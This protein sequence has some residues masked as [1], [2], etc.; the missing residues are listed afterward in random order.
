[1]APAA[2]SGRCASAK[3]TLPTNRRAICVMS[4]AD[5]RPANP[6]P[7][8]R[9]ASVRALTER[10]MAMLERLAE[11]GMEI[12]ED[13]GRM[14]RSQAEGVAQ[15][16]DPGLTYSRAARAVRLTIAL[17]QRLTEG[18]AALEE[19]RAKARAAEAAR[20]RGRIHRRVE[21]VAEAEREDADEAEDLSS[22]AWERLTE[23]DD[24]DLLDLP[25]EEVVTRI[26]RDLGL[27][28]AWAVAFA[29]QD[30]AGLDRAAAPPSGPPPSEPPS[31]PPHGAAAGMDQR[32]S[33]SRSGQ[34][35]AGRGGS[36]P[37]PRSAFASMTG[38]IRNPA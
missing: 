3:L 13:A 21:R 34:S 18:V 14:S 27:S 5:P 10:Q 24:D 20:L 4:P 38:S 9:D 30:R 22:C 6:P 15:A 33:G 36:N 23:T 16:A 29:A 8:A 25:I 17:Q 37:S 12:A 28:P 1:M 19:K 11:I 26:C 2:H 31:A 35:G 32:R 7:A